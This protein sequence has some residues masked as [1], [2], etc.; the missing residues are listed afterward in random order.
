MTANELKQKECKTRKNAATDGSRV[1]RTNSPAT[2]IPIFFLSDD[3][4][5]TGL[6]L[7]YNSQGQP[8]A[9][10]IALSHPHPHNASPLLIELNPMTTR[11]TGRGAES[12]D[13]DYLY[14]DDSALG[15]TPG[16]FWVPFLFLIFCFFLS[17]INIYDGNFLF[18]KYYDLKKNEIQI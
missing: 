13:F 1:F 12:L 10:V 8:R 17:L 4:D 5:R 3:D 2:A 18:I 6:M 9:C 14:N 15:L 16:I 7:L 11:Q